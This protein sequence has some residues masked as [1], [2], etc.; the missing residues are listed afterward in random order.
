L[1]YVLCLIANIFFAFSTLSYTR[2][3]RTQ[4]ILWMNLSKS[5]VAF[6]CCL[7]FLTITNSWT[8]IPSLKV[9][10]FFLSGM[11]GLGLGDLF[12]VSAF[13]RIGSARTMVLWGFQP[14]FV[15]FGAYLLF[16]ETFD[17]RRLFAVLLLISCLLTFSFEGFKKQ[18]RWEFRG[19]LFAMSGI[20]LD[21]VGWFFTKYGY[22][23][24]YQIVPME[25]HF[26]RCFGAVCGFLL[27]KQFYKF[28]FFEKLN[29][30]SG[31]DKKMVFISSFF[32]TFLAIYLG[33]IAIQI[34]HLPS[35]AAVSV[36]TPLITALIEHVQIRK[37][38]NGIFL[39]A[40]FQFLVGF[41]LLVG[42]EY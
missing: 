12:L 41:Y 31:Y 17:A 16:N 30:L 5:L 22:E 10:P 15:G 36:T 23:T 9:L 4:G 35:L 32:G 42:Y 28:S 26:Y 37:W 11:I 13:A 20:F 24:N 8:Q 1:P 3:A 34:G 27:I 7:A 18:G 39:F 25:G 21:A 40:L 33:L 38:P 2:F 14:V 6:I 29:A 19:L